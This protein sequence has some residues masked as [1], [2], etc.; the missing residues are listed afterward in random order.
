MKVLRFVPWIAGILAAYSAG[1]EVVSIH[2]D[3][4]DGD[5]VTLPDQY[6]G[7]PGDGWLE[8]WNVF[9]D[10]STAG[11]Y[12]TSPLNGGG[13]YLSFT[14][15]NTGT[16]TTFAYLSRLIDP[17]A[18]V[19]DKSYQP[20]RMRADIRLDTP[21]NAN[22][23]MVFF[24]SYEANSNI[25]LGA[26]NGFEIRTLVADGVWQ[27]T[28]RDLNAR[29]PT[30]IIPEQGTVYTIEVTIYPSNVETVYDA[31]ITDG[32]NTFT[33]TNLQ[34]RYIGDA[35]DPLR[36]MDNICFGLRD[37]PEAGQASISL[38]NISVSYDVV[39][40]PPPPPTDCDNPAAPQLA[41]IVAASA[42]QVDV[43]IR[44]LS[45]LVHTVETATSLEPENW[46][47]EPSFVGT[48]EPVVFSYDASSGIPA[49]VRY[50]VDL[51]D[52][53]PDALIEM[54]DLPRTASAPATVVTGEAAPERIAA[55]HLRFDE[56]G[57]NVINEGTIG[58][59][60]MLDATGLPADFHTADAGGVSGAAGDRA[61]DAN[62]SVGPVQQVTQFTGVDLGV[63]D[64]F[65]I[66][67]W[68]YK[69]SGVSLPMGDSFENVMRYEF[70]GSNRLTLHGS[71]FSQGNYP[72]TGS[73]DIKM[74][75][76]SHH[77]GPLFA[78]QDEWVF[79]AVTYDGAPTS[80]AA[81]VNWYVGDAD[82]TNAIVGAATTLDA[83]PF[84][85][86]VG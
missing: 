22:V 28:V 58:D 69:D 6:P 56:T 27:W 86:A 82:P 3:F 73:L 45:N 13:N 17:E 5:G 70:S 66:S 74:N 10:A 59:A 80:N 4:T 7:A 81:R 38:D 41:S 24:N 49:F 20:H 23:N 21:T 68:F 33:A 76:V 18:V 63:F 36:A 65:T 12:D 26:S 15:N 60:V 62:G 52:G 19:I 8:D 1:A 2:A 57:T 16:A 44:S 78:T 79:F 51:V 64:R 35:T 48:G 75:G 9:S 84:V 40:P 37:G 71:G 54:E 72:Q 31:T 85:I 32:V 50:N 39:A 47:A 42:T 83:D 30:G 67:G 29:I 55:I 43:E 53:G 14:E 11:V 61:F 34:Y 77:S 25:G 46:T